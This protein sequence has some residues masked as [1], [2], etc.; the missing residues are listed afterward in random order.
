VCSG[1]E[2]IGVIRLLTDEHR[3]FSP[4]EIDFAMMVAEEGGNAIE[5][6]RTYRKIE[7][8]FNQIEEH[9]RFLQTIMDSLWLQLVVIDPEKHV[10]MANKMFLETQGLEEHEVL[11]CSYYDV[12][13]W[14]IPGNNDCPVAGVVGNKSS[15]AMIDQMELGGKQVWFER[16][17]TPI[18]NDNGDVD[19][20]IEAVRDITDQKLLEQEKMERVKLE[21]I[22]E[23]AG[24]V[25]H[26]INTPLFSALGTAQLLREDISSRP[27]GE[28]LDLIIRNL[29]EIS[30]LSRKM[31][32]VTGFESHEYVGNTKIVKL[33]FER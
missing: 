23:L 22:V 16:H 19:S 17:L 1:K 30:N 5:K 20:V 15:I 2:I 24:T 12:S 26:K 7:L 21:G 18:I 14:A 13:P 27:E 9:E 10:I 29:E 33:R 4:S 3:L 28:E 31:N 8:L 11:G 25:A 6:A 32:H